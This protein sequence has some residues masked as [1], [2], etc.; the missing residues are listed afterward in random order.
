MI[1][2]EYTLELCN[3]FHTGQVEPGT[4]FQRLM[5]SVK[6]GVILKDVSLEV[7]GGEVLAV[8]GSKG[9]GKRAL[10][11][12][13]SR[14]AQGPTRGQILLNGAHMSLRLFQQNCGYVTHKCDLLPG[15][16]VEQ[17][18]HYASH[19]TTAS[20]R[21]RMKQVMADLALTQV[22]NRAVGDLTQSEYRRLAIGVQLVRDPVV[23]L[24]D[25]PTWDLD[26][27]NTYLVISILSNHARKYG[28]IVVLTM[29]KPRSDVFPFLDRVAYLCLG[30][31][32]YT[33]GT[34]L[35]L[36][37]FRSIGFPCPELENPLMYYLCLSTVDRRSRERFIE[38]NHQIAALVE[39]FKLEGGPFRR[40]T[41]TVAPGGVQI[42]DSAS[43][44]LTVAN[45]VPGSATPS[46]SNNKV[47][48]SAFGRPSAFAV[49]FTL[50]MRNLA[51]TFN[52][53]V[54]GL[55]HIFLRLLALP[56][57][58]LLLWIFYSG[59][60]D[61]QRTF[62]TRNGLIF[63]CLA[64]AYFVSIIVTVCT[65]PAFRT[66]YY[67][68]AQEGLY[69]GPLFLL[70]YW[71][72]A[73]PFAVISVG[74]A[75]RITFLLTGLQSTTDWLLFAA[76]QFACYLLAQQQTIALLL[77]VRSSFTAATVSVYI[78]VIYL[79]LGSGALRAFHSLSEWLVY[80][81]YATQPRYAGAFLNL[82]MFGNNNWVN[83]NGLPQDSRT[84]CSA[85]I[86]QTQESLVA[87][88]S[89]FGC[90]YADGMAYIME[91]Y[92]RDNNDVLSD[93]LEL[94]VNLAIAFAFPVGLAIFNSLLYLV[95]LPAF[96]KAKF[97]E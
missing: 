21:S 31:V 6:T 52:F 47:P 93:M 15:L 44:P 53:R 7:H 42:V 68:E 16:T 12:V 45:I 22:G 8:L 25:E 27:L 61:Y 80:L 48:L 19:I 90:R 9:S 34:R 41:S 87:A 49:A 96:I 74:A 11:E 63:N 39:K 78:T 79:M 88:S 56:V 38:S 3:V 86:P 1:R 40:K 10:L 94:D 67:Q 65:F 32:V 62:I 23:L 36:D 43:D 18:L 76:V 14:R 64:G 84:N 97:R 30:D 13:I 69:S 35:M 20:K 81:T 4:C 58:H 51:A 83:L 75:T 60:E 57:F 72:L 59:M 71:L 24:L 26:P 73:V 70:S 5:G 89:S 29:E 55:T 37:Y 54:A 33:G 77:V 82:Q 85:H 17:T 50:Y 28:R 95:P 46:L 91:R 92:G 2:N 66:R